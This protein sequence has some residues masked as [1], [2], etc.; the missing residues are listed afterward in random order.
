MDQCLYCFMYVSFSTQEVIKAALF[1]CMVSQAH[2]L[3]CSYDISLAIQQSICETS[4]LSGL[5]M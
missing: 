3:V 5:Q 4:L 1:E 2:T